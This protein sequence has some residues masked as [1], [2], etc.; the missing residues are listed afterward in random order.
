M[1][2]SRFPATPVGSFAGRHVLAELAG[3]DAT[4]LDDER[5]IRR[6][7]RTALE[8]ANAT[9]LDVASKHFH[10]QGVTAVALLSESH[11]SIH[12]YP[13]FGTVFIDVF[14][15][16]DR[17]EPAV[18]VDHLVRALGAKSVHTELISCGRAV[19]LVTLEAS[20]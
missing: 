13:E 5:L 4:L 18:A 19:G 15:C 9:V 10:P 11:A 7:L 6:T 12:T 20:A 8:R 1:I 16:G 2:E 3:V 17:A 14:T